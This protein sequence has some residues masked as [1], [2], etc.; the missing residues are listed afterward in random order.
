MKRIVHEVAVHVVTHNNGATISSCLTGLNK[1]TFR[2]FTLC[3]IDNKSTDNTIDIVKR[4]DPDKCIVNSKNTGYAAA[5]NQALS[6]TNSAYVLTLNPDVVLDARFLE[7]MVK[8]M[9]KNK[10]TGSLAGLLCRV[11]KLTDKAVYVDGAGLYMQRNRRQLLRYEGARREAIEDIVSPI[12]GPDGAAAFY[13][14][15]MLED[16]DLGSGVFDEDFFMHKEDVDIC[17]RAQL[18]GWTSLFVPQAIAKHIRTFRAGHRESI[19]RHMK[20]LAVRN[21]YYLMIKNEMPT[22]FLRDIIWITFYDMGI[23]F[24]LLTKEQYSL[25]AYVLVAQALPRLA[26]KR[27]RIQSTRKI[28][29][30]AIG[31]WFLGHI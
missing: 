13:R 26:L 2:D 17:W 12:F 29:T 11:E 14:R 25:V 19:D 6:K 10:Q 21:R 20:M 18:R 4:F 23:F 27:A 31:Q 1:Q 30:T 7:H 22:L 5:H 28:T 24:Y 16:I 8:V 9:K 3:V 15:K